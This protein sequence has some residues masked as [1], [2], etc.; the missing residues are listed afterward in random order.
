MT[1]SQQQLFLGLG[2]MRSAFSPLLLL[3]ILT[4]CDGS[5]QSTQD[6]TA[7]DTPGPQESP[8]PKYSEREGN[9]YFYKS[10]ISE[11]DK[12][13]GKAAGEVVVFQYR[14]VVDGVYTL[15]SNGFTF[16]CKNP[17]NIIKGSG[18]YGQES[19]MEFSPDSVIG[20]AFED[21]FNGFME[22]KRAVKDN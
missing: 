13:A 12:S 15:A 20:S 10:A 21:A 1:Q 2:H 11:D 7:T 14:G 19:N 22:P 18:P 9:K 3:L 5:D 6:I 8:T 16:R 4:S 17:C